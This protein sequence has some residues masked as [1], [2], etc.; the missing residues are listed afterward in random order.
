MLIPTES[1]VPELEGTK[2]YFTSNGKAGE[3]KVTTGERTERFIEIL[4]GLQFGDTVLT[5]GILQL[6]PGLPVNV[7]KIIN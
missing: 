7:T 2:I 5:T 6:R 3:S 4:S 1:I